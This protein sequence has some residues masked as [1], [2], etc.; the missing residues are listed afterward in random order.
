M[1]GGQVKLTFKAKMTTTFTMTAN[2]ALWIAQG[3]VA[4]VVVLAGAMKLAV[5]REK[6]EKKMHWAAEWPR[7]RI[8]LLGL[9][10]LV[11][12]VGLIVPA[13]TGI[14]PVLTP[15]A[16]LCLAVLMTGAIATHRRLHEGFAPAVVVALVCV[17]IAAGHFALQRTH[18]VET[19][20]LLER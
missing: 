14:A 6:L 11:G 3:L 1:A 9:A 10:E 13:A 17:G 4:L 16:A 19:Q 8:K 18:G 2:T 15:I 5:P 12:A 7:W 20:T